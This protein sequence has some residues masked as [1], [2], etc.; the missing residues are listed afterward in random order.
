MPFPPCPLSKAERRSQASNGIRSQWLEMGIQKY[1]EANRQK[2]SGRCARSL[3]LKNA[4]QGQNL[5]M[6]GLLEV[7]GQENAL[8][9]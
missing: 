5:E 8:R 6:S 3:A 1:P 7:D 4:C 9:L 2:V